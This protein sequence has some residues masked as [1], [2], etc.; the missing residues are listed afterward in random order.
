MQTFDGQASQSV[1]TKMQ[2]N[3]IHK[4]PIFKRNENHHSKQI[5]H[6][7]NRTPEPGVTR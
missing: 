1:D 6:E 4:N 7:N 5:T 3:V 2:N